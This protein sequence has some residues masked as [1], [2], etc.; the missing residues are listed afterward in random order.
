MPLLTTITP[1]SLGSP[2]HSIQRRGEIKKGIQI[3]KE[4]KLRLFGDDMVL[5]IEYP[6]YTTRKILELINKQRKVA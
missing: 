3:G 5:Y 6:K 4:V 1:H 2:S